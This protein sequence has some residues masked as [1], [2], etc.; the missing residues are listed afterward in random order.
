MLDLREGEERSQSNIEHLE[1]KYMYVQIK[2]QQ[3]ESKDEKHVLLQIIDISSDVMY[4]VT[5]A[6][7]RLMAL[8]NATVSHDMRNPTNAIHCQNLL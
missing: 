3:Y 7:K 8:M 4:D 6:E 2:R 5:K 1:N